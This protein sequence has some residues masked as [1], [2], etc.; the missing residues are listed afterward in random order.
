MHSKQRDNK[1][2]VMIFNHSN[3]WQYSIEPD[4]LR[5]I[6]NDKKNS[7]TL[8]FETLIMRSENLHKMLTL[9]WKTATEISHIF[10]K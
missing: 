3:F 10:A 6:F 5:V 1:D 7:Y 4:M 8:Y 9:F 2:N